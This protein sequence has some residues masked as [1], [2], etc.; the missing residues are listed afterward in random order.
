[1]RKF[2]LKTENSENN[3]KFRTLKQSLFNY[4]YLVFLNA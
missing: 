3:I 2:K 4:L 1:M